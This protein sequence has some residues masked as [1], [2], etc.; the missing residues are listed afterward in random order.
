MHEVYKQKTSNWALSI[1]IQLQS[2]SL[3]TIFKKHQWFNSKPPGCVFLIFWTHF[4]VYFL[5]DNWHHQVAKIHSPQG[6]SYSD[7]IY[8]AYINEM[9]NQH[10]VQALSWR[11]LYLSRSKL[12]ASSRTSALLAG[13]AMV[14]VT[15]IKS[16]PMV[17]NSTY[18]I[19]H[20]SRTSVHLTQSRYCHRPNITTSPKYYQS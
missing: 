20:A 11:K 16:V 2:V 4:S 9:S 10:S 17:I 8:R 3:Y 5:L 6:R 14:S 7:W 12:K 19:K 15:C 13:F 18:Q 1:I